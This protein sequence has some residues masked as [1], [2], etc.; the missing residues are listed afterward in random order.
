MIIGE[1]IINT[2]K[3]PQKN[4]KDI[5]KV[6]KDFESLLINELFKV[7][8]KTIHKTKLTQG[9]FGEKIFESMLDSEISKKLAQRDMLN[10]S[11]IIMN[12]LQ[13]N[14]KKISNTIIMPAIGKI[15]SK[16]GMRKHP[17]SGK[18]THHDGIDISLK[19][20]TEIKAA[21]SGKVI[22][23]GKQ[24]GYGNVMII[25]NGNYKTLYAHCSKLLFKKGDEI[26]Q[27]QKI[28]LSGNTGTSTGPHLHFE[29]RLNDKA[30]NPLNLLK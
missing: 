6:S 2:E 25:K 22:F 3:I 13:K 23:S 28:A 18:I 11:Q 9:G 26:K 1:K 16:F 27:G 20:G 15:T 24:K 17:I 30:I 8:R 7:M 12:E 10:I 4:D 29:I 19:E 21:M 5:K 14:D